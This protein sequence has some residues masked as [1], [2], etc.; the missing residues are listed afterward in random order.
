MKTPLGPSQLLENGQIFAYG[1]MCQELMDAP[2]P[3]TISLSAPQTPS[4]GQS[5]TY[6]LCE[7]CN[8]QLT[9]AAQAQLHYNGRSHLRRV[10]QLQAGEAGQQAS[11]GAQSR[12]LPHATGLCS[13]PAGLTPTP[14]PSPGLSIPTSTTTGSGCGTVG[15]A[16][17]GLIGATGPSVMMK[18][19]LSFPVETSTPVGLFP[20]FN[21]MDPVQKAVINHT[22]GVTLV[23]K[24]KQVISCN[25]C[26]LRFN[27]DSQ[28]EAHYRGSRH[29][30]K[31]KSQENKVK[32]KLSITGETNGSNTS[33][34][35]PAPPVPANIS[36]NQ[37]TELLPSLPDPTSPLKP[38]LLLSSSP[39]SSPSPSSSRAG[40][41]P[42]PSS[43]PSALPAPGLSSSSSSS[44]SSSK[45]SPPPP[46]ASAPVIAAPSVPAPPSSQ[47]S[48][49][50]AP[51]SAESEE[52]KAKK[53]LY[54][55]L[56]KVAVNS[57]SQL[58][59]HN[60]GSK[61]KTMLEAR[62]GA[63][64]IKAYPRPGA[65]LKN[66]SSSVIKGSGLQNKTFHCQICDVH[67]NSEIQLKQ[68]ISSRRHKDRVAGKPSKPKYSPYNK[69]QRSSLTELVKPTLSPSF[70]TTPFAPPPSSLPLTS[71]ISLPPT[72]LSSTLSSSPL[73]T[74]TSSPL[75]TAIS[76]H[77]RP[78]ASSSLF[79][80]SFLR[81]APG[82]IRASQGSILFTPY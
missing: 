53:L 3:T 38:F 70:L 29:A 13:Q 22:F 23:P 41:E 62:S 58:E 42:P 79:T 10:R 61:H 18:P 34:A 26:Q 46:P 32:A 11:A 77:P 49:Q 57:L 31:L 56:C 48:S 54:C 44:S 39:L 12:S 7:V 4:I 30:K 1:G 59:A 9:S 20:N 28:A 17:P 51:L 50:D 35:G 82:P 75:T 6:S 65:K 73:L 69:Q 80:A 68:H 45:S 14:G 71:T 5:G 24:K 76:L 19:F 66:G 36:T 47:A 52:E 2:I 8:L 81:P 43:P 55:S 74:A 21:T 27:S 25:V 63:G 67:V 33:P 60:A 16:L 78:P 15:G 64:P 72:S 37:H 40:S